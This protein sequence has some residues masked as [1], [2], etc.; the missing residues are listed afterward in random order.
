MQKKALSWK[1]IAVIGITA[2]FGLGFAAIGGYWAYSNI[3]KSRDI[4]GWPT[5]DAYI[6][7][8]KIMWDVEVSR[9]SRNQS[10]AYFYKLAVTF[11]Y[12][13]N[14]RYFVSQTA[15]INPITDSK[16]FG[17]DPWKNEPNDSLIN[18]LKQVPQGCLVPVHYNPQQPNE[19]YIFPRLTFWQQYD[20]SV[21]MILFGLVFAAIPIFILIVLIVG[22]N[23][24][25]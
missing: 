3:K 11:G 2:L 15:A 1:I 22:H 8:S 6:I 21:F 12:T 14:N 9:S 25:W 18:Y 17:R 23:D 24:D 7:E 16:F 13:I 10:A 4:E 5:T 20:S 19:A